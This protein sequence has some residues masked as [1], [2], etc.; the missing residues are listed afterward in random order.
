MTETFQHYAIKNLKIEIATQD[1]EV[2]RVFFYSYPYADHVK[3]SNDFY[4][5]IRQL[6]KNEREL[7]ISVS[8]VEKIKILHKDLPR[9]ITDPIKYNNIQFYYVRQG[10][11]EL[12]LI[13]RNEKGSVTIHV[14]YGNVKLKWQYDQKQREEVIRVF[15]SVRCEEKVRKGAAVIIEVNGPHACILIER[16]QIL[17][18]TCPNVTSTHRH[19]INRLSCQVK[20][21]SAEVSYIN[22]NE[23]GKSE[24]T[25]EFEIECPFAKTPISYIRKRM[26]MT[27][28]QRRIVFLDCEFVGGYKELNEK[29]KWKA[30]AL[31]ASICI[32]NYEGKIILNTR[33]TP[34]KKIRSYVK[35]IT[36]FT[37]Q[38]LRNK[39]KDIDVIEEV[40]RFV[41]GK[42]LVGHDLTA[43]MKVL[44]IDK[45]KLMGI[46][47]LSTSSIL[48]NKMNTEKMRLKL[49]NVAQA[50]LGRSTRDT[51]G[52]HNVLNDV[53]AIRD[54]YK[55]IE[56]EWT[57]DLSLRRIYDD[58]AEDE[59]TPLDIP[60]L[61]L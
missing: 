14:A 24:E 10:N 26:L 34:N 7:T 58:F 61:Y 18:E 52:C 43:D 25:D 49:E 48:K 38:D 51:K 37:P 45:K 20:I 29:G 44:N 41:K 46:R 54:I 59:P 56:T 17:N 53:Q 55:M 30:T 5:K 31:L 60:Y 23:F 2:D 22:D 27:E 33:V 39:R 35:W 11:Y 42:I 47:D 15:R 36:G 1:D 13:N 12:P 9:I 50:L 19:K 57:D 6:I 32:L 8:R 3:K 16:D 28:V 40:Q 21:S 4:R